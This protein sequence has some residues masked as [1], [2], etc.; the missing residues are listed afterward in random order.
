ME[1]LRRSFAAGSK[2]LFN[3]ANRPSTA[4]VQ[5]T[6]GRASGANCR[7]KIIV[8]CPAWVQSYGR[9]RIKRAPDRRVTAIAIMPG[10]N[11]DGF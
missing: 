8:I 9:T 4:P 11:L 7:Q 1:V 10:M 2:I 5:A 6:S 3:G